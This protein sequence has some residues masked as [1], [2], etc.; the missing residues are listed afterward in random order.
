MVIKITEKLEEKARESCCE[1][2]FKFSFLVV[3][4]FVYYM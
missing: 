3:V 1:Y 4:K 2:S